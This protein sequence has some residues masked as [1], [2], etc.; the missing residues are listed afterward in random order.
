M[1]APL[2]CEI[3]CIVYS[4]AAKLSH[5]LPLFFHLYFT[6]TL[7]GKYCYSFHRENL[8]MMILIVKY[9]AVLSPQEVNCR[10]QELTANTYLIL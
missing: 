5:Y 8:G 9:R 3:C 10:G 4:F 6:M 7:Q 2:S 1:H